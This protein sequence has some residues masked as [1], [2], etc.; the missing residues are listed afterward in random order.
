MKKFALVAAVLLLT[1]G[2]VFAES[3]PWSLPNP[4]NAT[5]NVIVKAALGGYL[6][7]SNMT[8]ETDITLNTSGDTKQVATANV[9]TN[10]KNWTLK[11]NA[12]SAASGSQT[13]AL[14]TTDGGTSY[15]IPYTLTLVGPGNGST[16]GST[17]WSEKAIPSAGLI[18]SYSK[19]VTG[20]TGGEVVTLSV[21]YGA[22]DV[23]NWFAGLV[24]TDTLTVTLSAN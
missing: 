1:T 3:V 23:A 11:V 20:G 14:V 5:S 21:T 10:L 19:R 6:T 2:F 4:A 7:I 24:Y 22:E 13:S 8:A 18:R 17:V 16:I 9:A 15:R 12:T